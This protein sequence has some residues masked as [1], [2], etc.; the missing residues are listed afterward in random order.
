MANASHQT[1]CNFWQ[2]VPG[3]PLTPPP[4][5]PS[6]PTTTAFPMV[7]DMQS[8]SRASWSSA[9]ARSGC[10]TSH[11]RRSWISRGCRGVSGRQT[12]PPV[13]ISGRKGLRG[14]GL[15]VLC[16]VRGWFEDGLIFDVAPVRLGAW[17]PVVRPAQIIFCT[18]ILH[19]KGSQNT[20]Y[21]YHRGHGRPGKH[22]I[23]VGGTGA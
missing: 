17:A 21:M 14:H 16:A 1:H 18:C 19:F 4:S 15:C 7:D 11:R 8:A 12:R 22:K 13:P 6:D 9:T 20:F 5:H 3:S 2:T 23:E 10:W